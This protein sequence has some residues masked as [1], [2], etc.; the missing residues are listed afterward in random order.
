[1]SIFTGALAAAFAVFA[2]AF[3]ALAGFALAGLALAGLAL[4]GL[5]VLA[6]SLLALSAGDC[7]A[8]IFVAVLRRIVP[9]SRSRLRTPA[10][11]V[12]SVMTVPIISSEISTSSSR[13]P[14]RS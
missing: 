1:M 10:S 3:L 13:R 14:L 11:R 4:A 8:A 12:Y 2:P 5:V 6:A 9:S 7:A